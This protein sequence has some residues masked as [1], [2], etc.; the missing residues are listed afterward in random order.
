M[1]DTVFPADEASLVT[2]ALAA[3]R[4]SAGV[5]GGLLPRQGGTSVLLHIA[6]RALRYECAVRRKVD[7][8]G[9]LPD[10][11]QRHA[12][13]PKTLLVSAPLSAEMAGRCRELGLEFIDTAGNAYLSDPG[14]YIWVTGRKTQEELRPARETATSPAALRMMF[15]F[16]AAPTLLN[17]SYRDLAAHAGISTGVIGK[18]L[19]ALQARGLVGTGPDGRRRILQPEQFLNEWASGYLG[20][21]KPR[22]AQYRFASADFDRWSPAQGSSA[23]GGEVGAAYLTKHLQPR[24]ATIYLDMSDPTLLASMVREYGLREQAEGHVEVVEMFWHARSFVEWFPTVPPHLVYADLLGSG[25]VRHVPV[26]QQLAGQIVE[27]LQQA[28]ER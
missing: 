24:T 15:A 13:G 6:G 3:L 26:A 23:W 2:R 1:N 25:D 17:A 22:L 27:R 5:D 12:G 11:A 20:R 4:A 9:L 8:Y 21:L 18:A 28:S 16:L 14:I 19:D 10:L 7:R